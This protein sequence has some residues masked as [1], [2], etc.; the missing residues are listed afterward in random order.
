M[1]LKDTL[2]EFL[3]SKDHSRDA[4]RWYVSRLGVFMTWATTQG[5]MPSRT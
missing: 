5:G 2:T 4:R 1:L 3:L